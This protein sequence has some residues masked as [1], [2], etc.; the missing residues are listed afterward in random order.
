MNTG[1]T[2]SYK[3]GQKNHWRRTMWNEVLKRTDGREKTQPIL[4]LAGPED[5]DREIA[6]SK[7][8][9]PQNLIAIDRFA[10]NVGAIRSKGAP[11]INADALDVLWSWPKDRPVC[12]VLMD[13]CGGLGRENAM[14]FDVFQRRPFRRSV[15]MVNFLRGRDPWSNL[16]RVGLSE[17]G[18]LQPLWL[19]DGKTVTALHH[20]TKHRAYQFLIF[21]ALDFI[22]SVRGVGTLHMTKASDGDKVTTGVVFPTT[23][24]SR[25]VYRM[26]VS[27]LMTQ[28]RPTFYTYKSGMLTFDSA[29]FD[30]PW[31]VVPDAVDFTLIDNAW[32]Q[33]EQSFSEPG[34]VRR[35]AA[36]LAVRTMR[37]TGKLG[38]KVA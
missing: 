6:V 17:S 14:V 24:E 23:P 2:R 4:Y 10:P 30:P 32:A 7:G 33:R 16:I 8:V 29:V 3:N 21:N 13:Y 27:L 20:D 26:G 28:M 34:L 19:S 1:A 36:M 9:P 15:A 25:E 35:L 11:A 37:L 5:M 31:G 22:N 18:L 12:A 38:R